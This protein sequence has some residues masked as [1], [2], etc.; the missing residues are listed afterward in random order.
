MI[1]AG[2]DGGGTKVE[3]VLATVHGEVIGRAVGG[4][5]NTNFAPVPTVMESFHTA[6]GGALS[7]AG[8]DGSAITIVVAGS[9]TDSKV[10]HEVIASGFPKAELVSVGEG[11]LALAAGGVMRQGVAIISGT[12][13]M[14][15][16]RD[17]AGV[18]VSVGGWGALLGDEGSA[19][20]IGAEALRAVC[21]AADGRRPKTRLVERITVR[22]ELER[23]R[24][25]SKIAYGPTGLTRT[26]IA[27]LS[28]LVAALAATGDETAYEILQTAGHRLADQVKTVIRRMGFDKSEVLDVIASGSVL[29]YNTI[30]YAVMAESISAG[31][32]LA[33]V[34]RADVS[35]G[36]GGAAIALERLGLM[37]ARRKLLMETPS[38]REPG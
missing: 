14:A 19:Y 3:C 8:V 11:R 29:H 35:P 37:E 27:A 1:C 21:R 10:L 4:T 26:Q 6:I 23:L 12:G 34:R 20:D 16:G 17:A 5:V 9:P 7:E 18:E 28:P 38:N 15:Y 33:H 36:M 30:V 25:L 22:F 32:P 13:S 24:D 2:I 31:Y